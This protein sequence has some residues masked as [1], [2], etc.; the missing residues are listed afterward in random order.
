LYGYKLVVIYFAMTQQE[1][2]IVENLINNDKQTLLLLERQK[3][4]MQN[5]LEIKK[6]ELIDASERAL[7]FPHSGPILLALVRQSNELEAK[8]IQEKM[9]L[10]T[11]ISNTKRSIEA[12][13]QN[14]RELKS[15]RNNVYW[16]STFK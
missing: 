16:S 2:S 4:T 5:Q 7:L 12:K 15:Q 13:E 3:S 1:I 9:T 6:R 8:F 10:E 11:Q 14:L